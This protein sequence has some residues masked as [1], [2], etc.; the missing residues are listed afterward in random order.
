MRSRM[1][2][3]WPIWASIAVIAACSSDEQTSRGGSA[4]N[5]AGNGASAGQGA[6]PSGGGGEGAT[7]DTGGSAGAP[8]GGGGEGGGGGP[9]AVGGGGSGGGGGG[10][11]SACAWSPNSNPCASGFYCDAPGCG[12]GTCVPL[13]ATDDPVQASVC[14]CDGVSYWNQATAAVH[15][16][17]VATAGACTQSLTCG[18]FAQIP[19]PDQ[20]HYCAVDVSGIGCNVADPGGSCWG[21]PFTCPTVVIDTTWRLC[22][23]QT[24]N[25]LCSAIKSGDM[26]FEDIPNCPQ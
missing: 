14:G 3:A 24:C 2:L 11:G 22:A 23:S 12:Q 1:R 16:M 21:L 9:S 25:D 7:G 19:C 18:G 10:G 6:A 17:A 13:G 8:E 5:G 4:G 15:G 26:F 20:K